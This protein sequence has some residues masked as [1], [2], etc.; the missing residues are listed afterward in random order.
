MKF[1]IA[2]ILLLLVT[3]TILALTFFSRD[4]SAD[5]TVILRY[6]DY[7]STSSLE[8]EQEL[9]KALSSH[10]ISCTFGIIPFAPDSI[11]RE[12]MRKDIPLDSSKIQFIARHVR[13][14]NIEI[15]LHGYTHTS[16]G[17]PGHN[18]EFEG[19][20]KA[21]QMQKISAAKNFLDSSFGVHMKTFIPPWN[22]YDHATLSVLSDLSFSCI[23][24]D[25]FG[26]SDLS[27]ELDYI[28]ATAVIS[29]V[30][31]QLKASS[32]ALKDNKA[33]FVLMMHD[34]D[35]EEVEPEKGITN[36]EAF[37]SFVEAAL[38]KD[39]RI[40]SLKNAV[41]EL[42]SFDAA[43]Y[44]SN[45]TKKT[46]LNHLSPLTAIVPGADRIEDLHVYYLDSA[47]VNKLFLLTV[48]YYLVLLL[49][50]WELVLLGLR[51]F[52][53]RPSLSLTALLFLVVLL[54]FALYNMIKSLPAIGTYD[55]LLLVFITGCLL[56]ITSYYLQ[57]RSLTRTHAE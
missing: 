52:K 3:F 44:R 43:R 6:D 51:L 50:I 25:N 18:T 14:E 1:R 22:S 54:V 35:F 45:K 31:S 24:A 13:Q 57:S 19:V 27:A 20:Q 41:E 37:G 47:T 10:D 39:W 40:L 33:V 26:V 21:E 30:E 2:G 7:S 9:L 56:G 17:N 15:A 23:S 16:A 48:I 5:V 55:L 42:G 29:D 46:L 38:A 34:Y 12:G 28:P 49:F 4:E 53:L 8:V 32:L 36:M 11:K